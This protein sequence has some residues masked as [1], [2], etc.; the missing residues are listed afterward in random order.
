MPYQLHC[1]AQV[2]ELDVATELEV[3]TELGV[4]LGTELDVFTELLVEVAVLVEDEVFTEL[5]VEVATLVEVTTDDEVR[6][7]EVLEGATLEEVETVPPQIA[8]VT[9]G[10][11]T[12]PLVF[13]CIPKLTVW[14]GW[15]A[16]FQL[17]LVALYGFEPVTV[18]F[19]LLVIR[20]L[21]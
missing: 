8:P 18:A 12:A 5:L 15:I 3:A 20:L 10:V 11:S 13:T 17:R 4:E 2:D 21:T 19:Q 16:P 6:D 1:D 7:D 14:P 9:A